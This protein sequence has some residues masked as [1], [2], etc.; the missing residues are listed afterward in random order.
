MREA[1]RR[2]KG[3]ASKGAHPE[4]LADALAFAIEREPL[5]LTNAFDVVD[6]VALASAWRCTSD[7]S[8]LMLWGNMTRATSGA[9]WN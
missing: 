1:G 4:D 6:P 5:D 8:P 2:R 3:R 7:W 9:A